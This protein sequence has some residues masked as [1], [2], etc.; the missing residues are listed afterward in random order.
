MGAAHKWLTIPSL[1]RDAFLARRP[2]MPGAHRSKC[3]ISLCRPVR[4]EGLEPPT[5]ALYGRNEGGVVVSG[6]SW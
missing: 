3:Q 4:A 5:F 2:Q 6:F 1:P